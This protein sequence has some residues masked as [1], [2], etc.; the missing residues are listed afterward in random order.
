MDRR[1]LALLGACGVGAYALWEPH[2]L[3]LVERPVPVAPGCP[4]LV[5]LHVSDTHLAGHNRH[6]GSWLARLPERLGLVPDLVLATGDLID[7]NE[8]IGPAID[9]L[10][11]L[12]ARLGRFYVLGSHDYY[13]SAFTG[14]TKYLKGNRQPRPAKAA[15]T[16]ALEAGLVSAGWESL[17]N[18]SRVIDAPEG[19]IRVSGVDDP[20]LGRHRTG[21]IERG[22]DERCAIGLVH[23][24]DV[25]SEWMLAG[26]DLVV[27]GHTHGGQIAVPGWGA[28]V[29]NSTLPAALASGLHRIG[30]GWLHVSPGLGHGRFAPVRLGS[31]PEATLLRL[32]PTS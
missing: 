13:V 1:R 21:H 5:V 28:L 12:E 8:G 18:R 4:E 15:D 11:P 7:T 19:P 24:P 9:A 10:T 26:Y 6:L 31:R 14:Y 23:S 20:Y 25:V 29:T 22:T 27:A 30:N 32:T 3:R 2:R 17:T 16:A